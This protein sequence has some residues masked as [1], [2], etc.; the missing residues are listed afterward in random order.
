M[1]RRAVAIT[2][3]GILLSLAVVCRES[4]RSQPVKEPSESVLRSSPSRTSKPRDP[5]HEISFRQNPMDDRHAFGAASGWVRPLHPMGFPYHDVAAQIVFEC[6]TEKQSGI[7]YIEF[8]GATNFRHT[9]FDRNGTM[10]VWSRIRWNQN[11]AQLAKWT[12]GR[13]GGSIR[14]AS[15]HFFSRK[16]T[17]GVLR[18]SQL[19]LEIG[20]YGEGLAHFQWSLLGSSKAIQKAR[21][22][23]RG[24]R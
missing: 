21:A 1:L 10:F 3:S 24:E 11:Q 6:N 14:P 13:D 19:L 12:V 4:P 23:C 15:D 16:L 18:Y 9:E 2:L 22:K 8:R 20:W 17:D 7:T 5:W